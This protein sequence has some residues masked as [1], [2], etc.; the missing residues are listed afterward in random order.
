MRR[1]RAQARVRVAGGQVFTPAVE[2]ADRSVRAAQSRGAAV[3]RKIGPSGDCSADSLG[4]FTDG[5]HGGARCE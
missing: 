1:A 2:E 5:T 3:D 4:D